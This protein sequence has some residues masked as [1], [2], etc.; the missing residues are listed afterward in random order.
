MLASTVQGFCCMRA[1]T[2]ASTS[3]RVRHWPSYDFAQIAM[4]RVRPA[5]FVAARSTLSRSKG[6]EVADL[7]ASTERPG[8]SQDDH[9]GDGRLVVN[10]R[11]PAAC[12][13]ALVGSK[14]AALSQ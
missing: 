11:D 7:E 10:L 13:A 4:S 14:A 9:A 5:A 1:G 12:D 2:S 6:V 8:A 3:P